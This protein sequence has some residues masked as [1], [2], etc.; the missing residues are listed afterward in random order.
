MH[1]RLRFQNLGKP[2]TAGLCG[3]AARISDCGPLSCAKIERPSPL[4]KPSCKVQLFA[5]NRSRNYRQ[6]VTATTPSQTAF[7]RIFQPLAQ[8]A[9]VR[10][11]PESEYT[12]GPAQRIAHNG[13]HGETGAFRTG[14]LSLPSERSARSQ[15]SPGWVSERRTLPLWDLGRE[16]LSKNAESLR[17]SDALMRVAVPKASRPR[18]AALLCLQL[19]DVAVLSLCAQY[20]LNVRGVG[21]ITTLGALCVFSKRWTTACQSGSFV[22]FCGR[23]AIIDSS[24]VKFDPTHNLENFK[25]ILIFL[26]TCG[27]VVLL[28]IKP[29]HRSYYVGKL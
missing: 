25:I 20:F 26:I 17:D 22:V 9:H 10:F 24:G 6:K 7:H 16:V 3:R 29:L 23:T 21:G 15:I 18:W 27:M 8:T 13:S 4:E 1:L 12:L 2:R 28:E 5:Q 14:P 11:T 19:G